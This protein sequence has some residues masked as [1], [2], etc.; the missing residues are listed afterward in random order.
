[1]TK[2]MLID[3]NLIDPERNKKLE[4]SLRGKK[5]RRDGAAFEL[6]VRKD[7]EKKGW[8]VAKWSNNLEEVELV[9]KNPFEWEG[10]ITYKMIPAKRKYN[11]FMKALAVGTGFPDFVI[12]SYVCRDILYNQPTYF[13]VGVE[14]KS[15][16]KLDKAE[17]SK[18]AYYLR[19]KI[20]GEIWIAFKNDAGKIEYKTYSPHESE[21]V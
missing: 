15:N 19:E 11:P 18:C 17:K 12:S 10:G 9:T 1:M 14:C 3:D 16:G 4:K 5:S 8:H 7:L 20:F 6:R 21:R 13:V 2:R